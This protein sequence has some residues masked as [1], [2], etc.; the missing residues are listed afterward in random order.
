MSVTRSHGLSAG[1]V[2]LPNAGKSTLFNSITHNS[3]PAENFPFCTIDKNLG[4]VEV[5]DER[6][7]K[8][9]KFFNAQKIVPSLIKYVDIAGLVK[10]ASEGEGLGNK[11][12]SH[13]REVDLIIYVLRTFSSE[14]ISHIY[15]RID[16]FEDFKIVQ[17]ELILKDVETVSKSFGEA[18]KKARVS[19]EKEVQIQLSALQKL[20]KAFEDGI[21][22][23]DI[24]FTEEEKD[25]VYELHLLSSKKR[26]FI[27]NIK[28]GTDDKDQE[29]HI[30][31]FK[32]N[33]KPDEIILPVDVKTLGD[34]EQM[35]EDERKEFLSLLEKEPALL[36]DIIKATYKRLNLITFYTGSE[37][38]CNAWS[39]VQGANVKEAAGVIHTD[40]ENGFV[41]ADVVNVNEMIDSGGFHVAKEKGI[42]RNHGKEYIVED[43]DYIIIY[44]SN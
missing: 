20:L 23:L 37:K 38:E 12:L 29:K 41:T 30:E 35:T 10:G 16:P 44:S 25:F 7:E 36:P 31:E 14:S 6:L 19:N 22:A 8:M 40:L 9:S 15:E 2:G 3:V 11:F 18:S 1:I 39:I 32:K 17:G 33:V 43:G 5:K 24:A 27:L 34:I 26:M 28:E 13:I 21:P 4:V 42:V